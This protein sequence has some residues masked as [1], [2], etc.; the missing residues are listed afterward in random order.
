MQQ[1]ESRH[2]HLGQKQRF[3]AHT[4]GTNA[5]RNGFCFF[6]FFLIFK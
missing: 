4:F 1:S 5:M 2:V 6:V 3:V